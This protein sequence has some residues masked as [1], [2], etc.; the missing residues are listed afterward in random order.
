MPQIVRSSIRILATVVY[1]IILLFLDA[2][3][4][5]NDPHVYTIENS[6][7]NSVVC[8]QPLSHSG[9]IQ[10]ISTVCHQRDSLLPHSAEHIRED[11]TATVRIH[12]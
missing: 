4:H 5:Q 6:M 2:V 3:L 8:N 1:H 7:E 11:C 10:P 12:T 9:L